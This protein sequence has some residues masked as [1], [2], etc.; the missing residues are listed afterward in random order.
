MTMGFLSDINNE[1]IVTAT[2]TEYGRSKLSQGLAPGI[3]KFSLS[4]DGVDYLKLW[5][6]NDVF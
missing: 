2:L 4:D 1:I 3:T 5:N 6:T